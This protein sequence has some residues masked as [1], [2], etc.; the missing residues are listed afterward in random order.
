MILRWNIIKKY[1]GGKYMRG[2]RGSWKTKQAQDKSA[3]L[4]ECVNI[5]HQSLSSTNDELVHTRY[6]M[7]PEERTNT[8]DL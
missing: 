1:R 3:H 6:S 4:D 7:G 8:R 2:S 5:I